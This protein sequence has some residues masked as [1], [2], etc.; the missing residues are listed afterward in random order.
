MKQKRE[1]GLLLRQTARHRGPWYSAALVRLVYC[2][3]FLMALAGLTGYSQA[4]ILAALTLA[5]CL[6]WGLLD[7]RHWADAFPLASLGLLL[8]VTLALR[9]WLAEGFRLFWED[10]GECLAART[11]YLLPRWRSA[12]SGGQSLSGPVFALAVALA[13]VPALGQLALSAPVAAGVCLLA[14]DIA[15]ALTLGGGTLPALALP[16]L[17]VA[18]ILPAL[19]A[20]RPRLWSGI[21]CGLMALML[22]LVWSLG[23]LV[24]APEAFRQRLHALRYDTAGT[25]LPEGRLADYIQGSPTV[26]PALT[27]TMDVPQA[28]YLRGFT[29]DRYV[30]GTWMG[31][32]P[33][34]LAETGDLLSWLGE[35][36][37]TAHT[38][39]A[40]AA[41]GMGLDTATVT[42]GNTGACGK[43]MY[44][45]Y[46]LCRGA[47]EDRNNLNQNGL[48][49]QSGREYQYTVLVADQEI[50]SR[51]LT[52]VQGE[53][54][55]YRR[56]ESAYRAFVREAY[57]EVPEEISAVLEEAWQQTEDDFGDNPQACV[58]EFLRACFPQEGESQ[59]ALPLENAA[60]TSY[61]YATVAAMTL[62]RFGIPA[63]YAEGYVIP[64]QTAQS[65]GGGAIGVD[66]SFARAWVEVY[67][68]GIGWIPMELTPGLGETAAMA[69]AEESSREEDEEPTETQPQEEEEPLPDSQ[70]GT[71]TSFLGKAWPWLAGLLALLLVVLAVVLRRRMVLS[72]RY[73]RFRNPC[74]GD[75]V[76]W[77]VADTVQILEKT[78]VSRKNG[79]LRDMGPTLESRF[80]E[81][82]LRAF[83][84]MVRCNDR[85]LFSS[86]SLEEESRREALAF[87]SLTIEKIETREKPVRR[88]WMRWVLCLY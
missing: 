55:D 2:E 69:E 49:S 41:E 68:E 5:L 65:A 31:L 58:V 23:A 50:L 86:R 14:V 21:L 36:V 47:Y 40:A 73:R 79:S 71:V 37:F 59:V 16:A 39:F 38:Q 83:Q 56:A 35:N 57:L 1:R 28:L 22:T 33:E 60:M 11:G 72:A 62:R 27:V 3:G 84:G 76:A 10:F 61:Q 51:V 66:S 42:V 9:P 64:E 20:D 53:E 67:Q 45:P 75:G 80:G 78:G 13:A 24:P 34:T 7:S 8:V 82:Y 25:T 46:Q 52:R 43:W 85:A 30:G 4:W 77:I 74:V 26:A 81:E 15:G 70:G 88:W 29:G 32:S 19:A 44:V 6:A 18:A 63:R 17:A 48:L 54:T 87:R 12:L